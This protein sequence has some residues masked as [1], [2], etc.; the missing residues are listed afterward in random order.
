MLVTW[1]SMSTQ[2]NAENSGKK[3]GS[4]GRDLC[5]RFLHPPTLNLCLCDTESFTAKGSLGSTVMGLILTLV[6]PQ[7]AASLTECVLHAMYM[8]SGC[9]V[10][11]QERQVKNCSI[12]EVFNSTSFLFKPI[13]FNHSLNDPYFFC[14]NVFNTARS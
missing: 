12:P 11:S 6:N 2:H 13:Q 1:H 10:S 4:V 14:D 7:Y 5:A 9:S 8:F 3:L